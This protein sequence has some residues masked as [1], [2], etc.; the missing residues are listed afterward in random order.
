MSTDSERDRD[1]TIAYLQPA[2]SSVTGDDAGEDGSERLRDLDPRHGRRILVVEDDEDTA[3]LMGEALRHY[4]HEP[5]VARDG[6]TALA[7]CEDHRPSVAL[8]DL[9]LPD[10]DGYEVARRLRRLPQLESICIIAVTG[11]ASLTDQERTRLAGFDA[12]VNKPVDLQYLAQM[13]DGVL[14]VRH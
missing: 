11:Y 7:I 5:L 10:M 4:G 12:H 14:P 13:L 1:P 2:A 3:E 8:I 9:G 6:P